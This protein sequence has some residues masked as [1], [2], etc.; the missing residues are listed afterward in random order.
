MITLPYSKMKFADLERCSA[1]EAVHVQ[2]EIYTIMQFIYCLAAFMSVPAS[3]P[4]RQVKLSSPKLNSIT[5]VG[6][7][8]VYVAVVL[9]GLDYATL[10]STAHFSV[11]CTVRDPPVPPSPCTWPWYCWVW[12]TPPSPAQHT[13]PSCAR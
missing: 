9:L 13:S 8:L 11:V 2:I 10:S 5:A 4:C 1:D 3:L 12:T 6:C 7:M